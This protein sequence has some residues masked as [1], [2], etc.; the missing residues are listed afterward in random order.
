MEEDGERSVFLQPQTFLLRLPTH[1]IMY[2]LN[3]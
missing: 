2:V 3:L 1:K